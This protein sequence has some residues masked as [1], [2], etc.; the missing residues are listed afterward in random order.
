MIEM[1]CS[2]IEALVTWVCTFVKTNQIVPLIYVH[3]TVCKF[4]PNLKKISKGK[5]FWGQITIN[6]AS[7]VNDIRLYSACN[8]PSIEIFTQ[9]LNIFIF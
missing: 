6:L 1:F 4:Y 3:F 7:Q 9:G 8:R 5:L 2:L